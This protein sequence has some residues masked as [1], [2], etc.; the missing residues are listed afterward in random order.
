[1]IRRWHQHQQG[2]GPKY[3]RAQDPEEDVFIEQHLNRSAACNALDRYMVTL[4][5]YLPL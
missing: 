4:L 5:Q 3:L 2:T 1:M